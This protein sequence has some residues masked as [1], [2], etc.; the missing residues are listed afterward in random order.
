MPASHTNN[1]TLSMNRIRVLNALAR[2]SSS[3]LA[4]KAN[5][6]APPT[7]RLAVPKYS[8]GLN[9]CLVPGTFYTNCGMAGARGRSSA[10]TYAAASSSSAPS[11]TLLPGGK[12]V[13]ETLRERGLIQDVTSPELETLSSTQSLKVYCGFDPTAESLHL[14]NLLGIIVLSWF[15]RHGHTPVALLG[16][17]T[18]RVGDPSGKSA[19]RPVM[20]EETIERNTRGIEE[21]LRSLLTVPLDGGAAPAPE[22]VNNLSWLGGMGLLT[23][24]R[25]VGKYA[26]VGTMINKES[27]RKRMESES[28][29]SYT[30]FTYQLLQGYD[31]VHLSKEL[32]IQVQVGGS[33]QWGNILAG[34]ELAR[35]MSGVEDEDEAK[36]T[37]F[38]MTFPLL[39]KADGTK[40]GKSESGALWLKASMLS[41]YKFYQYL[42]GTTDSDV[43]KFIKMLTFLPMEEVERIERE[44]GEAGYVPNTAQKIL[45]AEVTKFVHGDEGLRQA[46]SATEALA[47]GSQTK[48][49]AEALE[50]AAGDCPTASVTGIVGMLLPDVMVEVGM[51]P[52]KAAVRRMIKGGGV[53]IN[54]EKVEEELYEIKAEDVIDGKFV[55]LAAG[56]KNKMLI[57]CL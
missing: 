56:K 4:A 27:V 47:P 54:N 12:N 10:R 14:G 50:A 49:S 13:V 31:F 57:E 28:G 40:F 19:E 46:L 34:T 38:G 55:L 39:R 37:T 23:F 17:A 48:L 9:A 22:I 5:C 29:I 42:L 16:G 20:S 21:T 18:G 15:Q 8:A 52:T 7:A 6:P 45:A 51:Q 35:K 33:D 26:R 43:V 2:R 24:L 36:P 1:T 41:P 25:D 44:M 30:E 3:N 53:R 11:S 32:G